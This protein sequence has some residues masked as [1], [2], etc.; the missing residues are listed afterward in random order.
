[1][2]GFDIFLFFTERP[3]KTGSGPQF[4]RVW[5]HF[6]L[7]FGSRRASSLSFW[8]E[9]FGIFLTDFFAG[10]G[11]PDLAGGGVPERGL[12]RFLLT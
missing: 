12:D 2:Y 3:S 11:V 4:G 7:H 9:F 5:L 1:M 6:W 10:G 8:T